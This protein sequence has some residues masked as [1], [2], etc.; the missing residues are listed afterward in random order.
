[1]RPFITMEP[2]FQ[3][4]AEPIAGP[5]FTVTVI[6]SA[7][8]VVPDYYV[9]EPGVRVDIPTSEDAIRKFA[10]E[11]ESELAIVKS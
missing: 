8:G 3:V 9:E 7:Y 6:I 2:I 5:T 1:M 4:A 10:E 11:L